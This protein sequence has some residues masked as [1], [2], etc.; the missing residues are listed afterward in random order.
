VQAPN[1]GGQYLFLVRAEEERTPEGRQLDEIR[2]RVFTDWYQPKK[3]ALDIY[4][5]PAFSTFG[6]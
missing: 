3:E 2:S 5:D 1:E 6:G 4:R